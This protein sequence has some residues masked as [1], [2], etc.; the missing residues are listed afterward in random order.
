MKETDEIAE[1][2]SSF[3]RA[4]ISRLDRLIASSER[5]TSLAFW[6]LIMAVISLVARLF[7]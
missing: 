2:P 1:S 4:M 3:Q 6:L 7:L 5:I